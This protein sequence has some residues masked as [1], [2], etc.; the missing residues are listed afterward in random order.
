MDAVPVDQLFLVGVGEFSHSDTCLISSERGP[1]GTAWLLLF[2]FPLASLLEPVRGKGRGCLSAACLVFR[3]NWLLC[4]HLRGG[5]RALWCF[6][7]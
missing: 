7:S 4:G 1:V 5:A 2:P 6:E 3:E